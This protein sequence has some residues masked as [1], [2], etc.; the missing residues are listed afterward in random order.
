VEQVLN[1]ELAKVPMAVVGDPEKRHGIILAKNEL[2][3]KYKIKRQK[4]YGRLNK[5]VRPL[6]ACLHILMNIINILGLATTFTI[7]TQ[8]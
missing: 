1:P 6:S 3:K 4:R 8:I 7:A 2:A 5:S